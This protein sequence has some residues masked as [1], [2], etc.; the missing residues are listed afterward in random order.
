M[1]RFV[2]FISVVLAVY[3]AMNIMAFRW[4]RFMF[5]PS[6]TL[7]TGFIAVFCLAALTQPAGQY[8]MATRPGQTAAT[9][10]QA[11][12]IWLGF[13]FYFTLLGILTGFIYLVLRLAMHLRHTPAD[14]LHAGF[15]VTGSIIL[16]ILVI[17]AGT[18]MIIARKPVIR[19]LEIAVP[20]AMHNPGALT[21]VQLSDIHL[22]ELRSVE[23][24][25]SIVDQT[26]A[27]KPDV[28]VL[29]GDNIDENPGRLDRFKPGLKR[30]SAP[31]GVFAVTGNHEFYIDTAAMAAM[32]EECG[33][34]L[35]RNRLHIIPGA[36]CIIGIDD[37]TGIHTANL[38]EPDFAGLG[39]TIPPGLPVIV[40]NHQP[41]YLEQVT[42]MGA[43]VQLSGHTH[44]GQ[45]W[46]FG[47]FTRMAFRY[48][49]GYHF[50]DGLH[51]YV[52]SGTGIWGPPFR[53]GTVS[54]IV[55]LR[56]TADLSEP[57][58]NRDKDFVAQQKNNQ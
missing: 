26:N 33:I 37:P 11:G 5:R 22:D 38:P 12:Y 44:N 23:W 20:A 9:I 29:T 55:T 15:P 24:W 28:I 25:E 30:L 2:V 17:L 53:I 46:P 36:A 50:I 21:I 16:S 40:L 14:T 1:N 35:L 58:E 8:L 41:V 7:N 3:T 13:L 10:L 54:E 4:L 39:R 49:N 57:H 43:H 52:S 56:I 48:N 45:I 6:G 47:L 42:A 19:N 34:I 31:F 18:G 32:L 51:L 27:L